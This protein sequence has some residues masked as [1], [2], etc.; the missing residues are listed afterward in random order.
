VEIGVLAIQGSVT[1]HVEALKRAAKNLKENQFPSLDVEVV[2]VRRPED[3]INEKQELLI[4]GIILPGGESTAQA[5]LLKRY[6]LF[7]LLKDAIQ[8]N[9]QNQKTLLSVW[10]TC[11]G[12]ILLSKKTSNSFES[13][14]NKPDILAVMDI[15]S[16]RNAYG[17]QIDSFIKKIE[18]D[19]DD[20]NDDAKCEMEAVFI[21]APKLQPFNV[22]DPDDIK[23]SDAEVKIL[24]KDGENSVALLQK[25]MLVTSFHPELTDDTMFHEFFLKMCRT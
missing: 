10:G 8:G 23:G 2:E 18:C 21:R 7:E 11:A 5:K 15:E 3:L 24:A 19:F 1:E 20:G 13:K 9:L 4:Q 12:A 16:D 17:T 25:N 22:K 14:H 6:G